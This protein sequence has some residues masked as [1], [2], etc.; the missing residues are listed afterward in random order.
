MTC[1]LF[2]RNQQR[3]RRVDRR[4]L[5]RIIRS[6]LHDDLEVVDYELTIHLVG[7]PAMVRLNETYLKHEGSTDVITFD[8]SDPARVA[9]LSGEIFICMNEA[10]AQAPRFRSTWQLE[11]V[12]YVIHGL[13]HLSGY[14]DRATAARRKMKRK[15]DQ[16]L[17]KLWLRF[18]I[19]RI[20]GHR[21]QRADAEN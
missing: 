8:Y 12:R 4:H 18:N 21:P 17:R 1:Q 15:E 13:L 9:L 14:D 16:L 5:C 3:A 19:G 11:V 6:V 10:I 7:E 2:L 20:G